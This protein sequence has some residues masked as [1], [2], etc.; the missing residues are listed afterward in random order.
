MP[1]ASESEGAME[2]RGLE[3]VPDSERTGHV[4]ELFPTWVAAKGWAVTVV[5][6]GALYAV[7]RRT[8]GPVTADGR[9]GAAE[10]EPARTAVSI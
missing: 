9:V 1:H 4:R 8:A 10:E 6:A 2:T 7:L 3:P 5:V